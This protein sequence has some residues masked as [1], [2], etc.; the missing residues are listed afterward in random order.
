MLSE[1]QRSYLV[2]ALRGVH[3]D[4]IGCGYSPFRTIEHVFASYLGLDKEPIHGA[5][6]A[7]LA[8]PCSLLRYDTAIVSWPIN[9]RSIAWHLF[10]DKYQDIVYLGSN[11]DGI[12]CG[13]PDF[14]HIVGK[15][16]VVHVIPE[17]GNTLIHYGKNQRGN[18]PRPLEEWNGIMAWRGA[19][20]AN[21]SPEAWAA[22][23]T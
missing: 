2:T 23:E 20:I 10:L 12:V 3:V 1:A 13:D 4:D 11:V 21:F 14:W 16:E 18:Q 8:K 22:A 5:T 9:R 17:R 19:P 15:R 7:D 6:M